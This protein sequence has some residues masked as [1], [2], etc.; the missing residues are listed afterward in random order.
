MTRLRGPMVVVVRK[1]EKGGREEEGPGKTLRV[2]GGPEKVR[3]NSKL[4]SNMGI[5]LY[6][7]KRMARRYQ[8][9]QTTQR[10]GLAAPLHFPSCCCG[11]DSVHRRSRIISSS[12]L[13]RLA[14]IFDK[15]Y[16]VA[17]LR[18][19]GI[20]MP[21][22]CNFMRKKIIGVFFLPYRR[23]SRRRFYSMQQLRHRG[24]LEPSRSS[25]LLPFP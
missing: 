21:Y 20:S 11:N 13:T 3:D 19:D 22:V 7:S 9:F 10:T 25:R 16:K 12:Q 8:K 17:N 4:D 1:R 24:S 15:T 2:E 14:F 23:G 5:I 18:A 6:V